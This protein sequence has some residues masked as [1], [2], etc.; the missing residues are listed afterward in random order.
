MSR[1]AWLLAGTLISS[2]HPRSALADDE[3]DVYARVVVA[4]TALRAGPGLGHRLIEH[5]V[6]GDVFVVHGREGSGF[7][8][9]VVLADGR[10]AFVL[11]DT[12]EPIATD[13]S[14]ADA[15][16]APGF[17]APPALERAAGGIAMMG[18]LF[19]GSGYAQV[20][21]AIVL[22]PHI[23]AEPYVGMA[24]S[25]VGRQLFY[26]MGPTINFGPDWPVAPFVHLGFGGLT[27]TFSDA[28]ARE[29]SVTRMMARAGGGL[30]ISLR[31]RIVIRI[32]AMQNVLF[33]PELKATVQSYGSG[34]GTYF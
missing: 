34:L 28:D 32:E 23:A 3:A 6:R 21:P 27:T 24:L 10:S 13:G 4:E 5:A 11:A 31:W 30:L 2:S 17:F 22:A 12:V 9:R 26:G 25:R 20:A 29:G 16:R 15:P 18:G 8:L 19:D 1:I 14:S 33:E 7:W